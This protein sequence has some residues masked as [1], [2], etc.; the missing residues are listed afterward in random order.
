MKASAGKYLTFSLKNESYG[1]SL[2]KVKEIIAMQDITEIPK[3][4]DFIKGVINLRGKIVSIMDLRLKFGMEEKEYTE[5]TCIIVVD[6]N[7]GKSKKQMGVA[8]DDVAEVIDIKE[9][10]IEDMEENEAHADREFITGIGKVKGKVI[11]L[12]DIENILSKKDIKTIEG[13]K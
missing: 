2:G 1:I 12:L 7:T 6:I 3:T 8:V 4:P 13:I 10:E 11:I 9:E 5:R